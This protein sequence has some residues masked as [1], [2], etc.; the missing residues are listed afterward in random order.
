MQADEAL[1][2][3]QLII[4]QGRDTFGFPAF[5][6]SSAVDLGQA[7]EILVDRRIAVRERQILEEFRRMLEVPHEPA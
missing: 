4:R 2:N 5:A 7:I 6:V 1:R 3:L